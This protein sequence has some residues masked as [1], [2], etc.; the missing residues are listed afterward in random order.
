MTAAKPNLKYLGLSP[1]HVVGVGVVNP[2]ET[3]TPDHTAYKLM[4]ARRDVQILKTKD[5][6]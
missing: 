1:L 5:T 2:N 4:S 6:N 3:V